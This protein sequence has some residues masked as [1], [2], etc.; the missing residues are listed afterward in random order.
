MKWIVY[1]GFR[2]F[3]DL[4][5]VVECQVLVASIGA[6]EDDQGDNVAGQS[7]DC[8]NHHGLDVK[9]NPPSHT[10]RPS[11]ENP[12]LSLRFPFTDHV[13]RINFQFFFYFLFSSSVCSTLK[14][15][16]N[17]FKKKPWY[18]ISSSV[19]KK[20]KERG[21][22]GRKRIHNTHFIWIQWRKSRVPL[23]K[24]Q[25]NIFF[26]WQEVRSIRVHHQHPFFK[27]E[28]LKM[29]LQWVKY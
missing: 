2:K 26:H 28:R 5:C 8:D 29:K 13:F 6:W 14:S 9:P 23:L 12:C 16:S 3:S 7:Q 19:K 21:E 20:R 22:K 10:W 17:W 27:K 15:F 4:W 1:R 11:S 18:F 25:L 24:V